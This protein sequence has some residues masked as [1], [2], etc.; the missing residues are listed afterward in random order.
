MEEKADSG[1]WTEDG[2]GV[3]EKTAK[4]FPEIVDAEGEVEVEAVA[5]A[6]VIKWLE[7]NMDTAAL[8]HLPS[9][10]SY[11]QETFFVTINGNEESCGPSFSS[12]ASTVMA[13]VDTTSGVCGVPYFLGCPSRTEYWQPALPLIQIVEDRPMARPVAAAT[14]G[15]YGAAE[16]DED[17]MES[18]SRTISFGETK[19]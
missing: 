18:V 10:P 9:S 4:V 17:E 8:P 11:R 6:E 14:D 3:A 7:E 2:G 16:K 5:V 1:K 13:S 12:S 15:C 19:I